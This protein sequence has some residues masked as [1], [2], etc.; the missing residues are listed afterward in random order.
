MDSFLSSLLDRPEHFCPLAPQ[1]MVQIGNTVL[2]SPFFFSEGK[3]EGKQ[4]PRISCCLSSSCKTPPGKLI[5][6]CKGKE[7]PEKE[8]KRRPW[9]PQAVRGKSW[10]L[11][12]PSTAGEAWQRL[13]SEIHG[14]VIHY[15]EERLNTAQEAESP[16]HLCIWDRTTWFC[17]CRT[18]LQ[19]MV[20]PRGQTWA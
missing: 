10:S 2:E 18:M 13:H 4:L 9:N 17:G 6:I 16:Q 7:A 1:I 14:S 12:F 11:W 19:M 20:F 8:S 5:R 3:C 15:F